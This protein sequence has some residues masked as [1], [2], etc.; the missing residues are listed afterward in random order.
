MKKKLSTFGA[1][2]LVLVAGLQMA[3]ALPEPQAASSLTEKEIESSEAQLAFEAGQ[4]EAKRLAEKL[5]ASEESVAQLQQNL[6]NSNSELEVFRRQA[7]AL[8]LRLEAIGVDGAGG[9]TAVLEQRLVKALTN[10]RITEEER[11]ALKDA[12]V[13]LTEAVLTYEK[14]TVSTNPD[15]RLAL[16]AEMRGAAKALGVAPPQSVSTNAVSSTLTD[17]AVISIKEDI[18]LVVANVGSNHGVQVGMPFR[19]IRDGKII[20]KIRVVDVREKIAGAVIQ[21]LSSDKAKIEV[22]DRLTVEA[23]LPVQTG[24]L[25]IRK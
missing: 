8:K 15:S 23:V 4:I 5:A 18:A 1:G 3:L 6:A 9:N 25:S 20:G 2:A 19:V 17:A 24:V 16:E 7:G 13:R 10:L 21:D 11:K 12:L 14:V 22:G